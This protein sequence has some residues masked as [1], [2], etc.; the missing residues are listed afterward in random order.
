MSFSSRP[1][2]S[3][4]PSRFTYNDLNSLKTYSS[5]SPLRVIALVDYDGYYAKCE[6][7]RLKLDSKTLLAVQ[8]CNAIIALKYL[9]RVFGFKRRAPIEEVKRLCQQIVL[10]ITRNPDTTGKP[11]KEEEYKEQAILMQFFFK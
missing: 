8:Q 11:D 1:V 5:H 9:A 2:S 4:P 10:Y 7:V 6:I 3:P